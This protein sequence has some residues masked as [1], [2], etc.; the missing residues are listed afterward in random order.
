MTR[1]RPREMRPSIL[2]RRG[3]PSATCRA[4]S[5][6]RPLRSARGMVGRLAV[7]AAAASL[8]EKDGDAQV[9]RNAAALEVGLH[10]NGRLRG[11][12][13]LSVAVAERGG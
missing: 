6:T 2:R 13:T 3:P 7:A 9:G 12:G 4:R 1:R 8:P 5:L 11:S 10:R